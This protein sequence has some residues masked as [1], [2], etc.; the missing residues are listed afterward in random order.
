MSTN[1][2][3]AAYSPSDE[4]LLAGAK[5][6]DGSPRFYRLGQHPATYR[7]RRYRAQLVVLPETPEREQALDYIDRTLATFDKGEDEAMR[8]YLRA[9]RGITRKV[10]NTKGERLI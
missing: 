4:K 10:R 7:C 3:T 6:P 8:L 5:N 1:N 2:S 9:V